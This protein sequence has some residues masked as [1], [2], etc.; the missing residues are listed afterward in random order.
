MAFGQSDPSVVWLEK[1]SIGDIPSVG[2]KNASL[3]E[4]VC[5]LGSAGVRVPSGFATTASAFR[6]FVK[7][8]ALE[9]AMREHIQ[10]YRSGQETLQDAGHAIRELML[11][12]RLPDDLAD[13]IRSAYGLLA[14]RTQSRDPAVAVRS[15]ATAEDLPDASFAG[16]HETF[17]NIRGEAALIDACLRC[18]ASLFTDRAISYRETKGFDHFAVALSVGVQQM[19][20]SDLAGS[21][22]MFTIDTES[23]FPGVATI[24]AAWGLGE[25][26]VQGAVN[27]DHYVVFKPLLENSAAR[28]II[29]KTL[30]DKAIRMIYAE[31]G[32][33][34]T[35][36][37][38]ST[39][40][41]QQSFVLNDDEI[42]ELGR[43]AVAVE[44]HYGRAMDLEWAK[45]GSNG[46]LYLVQ[47]RPE[48]IH[49]GLG[50]AS[51]RR[52]IFKSD[53]QP[54]LSGVSIGSA[55]A[56]GQVCLIHNASDIAHFQDGAILVTG[57]TDPDWVPIMKRAAGIVTDR[58]GSTSHAAI[59]SREL[60]VPAVVG[61]G[62]ATSILRD[63]QEITLSCASGDKGL[64]FEGLLDFTVE[65]ID[66]SA[67]PETR[68]EVMLN[69]ADPAAA[70]QWWRLP[71]KGV[72]LARMEFIINSLIKV[73][74]MALLHPERVSA[75]DNRQIQELVRGHADPADYFVDMLARGIGRLAAPFFPHPAIVRLSDFKTNEYAHLIGGDAFEPH[76]ENAMLG[77][78]GASRYYDERYREG[79]ALE[80]RALRKVREEMGFANVIV[81]V[82]FCRT[83]AEADRVLAVMAENGLRRGSDELQIYMMC[84]IPSNVILAEQFAQRFDG[85]SIGSNDLTQ[86]LL[87]VDRD[88]ELLA[89]MF[90]ERDPAVMHAIAEAIRKAHTAGIK[91]GICGQA[92]SNYPEFAEFLVREG[93]DSISL[94]PDSF[95][96]TCSA[97]AAAEVPAP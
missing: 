13:Q 38:A 92:P 20:R 7:L 73:H 71:A 81:M 4:L 48:T 75:T 70:F 27:P 22:V 77:F 89:A 23:G 83:P 28:P 91:I 93:I 53:A 45:D 85:F 31:E 26:I 30:G 17:L 33:R 37:V 8:N 61:T 80:C 10:C 68:T 62:T 9:P 64:I 88:S 65:D 82:P 11:A 36:I 1:L 3:G 78:R 6:D 54:I 58:G 90:D 29:E 24:S 74:P 72:G 42:L 25:T 66:L 15:S 49:G 69:I 18:F 43:W 76:E 47:A 59:V 67:I 56:S 2:G 34:Q 14:Q 16:Q 35:R 94:N 50:Q 21:G 86:L 41:E 12:S 57:N 52:Y 40:A 32:G 51:F 63:G 97:I 96:K 84:E 95:V 19:V 79:F 87:G 55:A 46:L 39:L 44:S 5:Q 60:G